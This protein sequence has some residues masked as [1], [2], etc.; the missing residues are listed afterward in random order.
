MHLNGSLSESLVT[1]RID[2]PVALAFDWIHQ[3]LYWADVGLHPSRAKI[4]V[5]TLY[6]RWRHTL[7]DESVVRSPEVVVVD[8]RADQGYCSLLL[9]HVQFTIIWFLCKLSRNKC[10]KFSN[11]TDLMATFQYTCVTQLHGLDR[12]F[13][14]WMLFCHPSK[15]CRCTCR[16]INVKLKK[17]FLLSFM[18]SL[19][20]VCVCGTDWHIP[21]SGR[22]DALDIQE[23]YV[24]GKHLHWN[25]CERI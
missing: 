19:L 11:T 9:V 10:L 3:N 20:F 17:F 7:L 23:M 16:L 12:L 8:P 25:C 1:T 18:L 13:P 4:E 22:S 2:N 15:Q 21:Q 6:N 14:D 24:V 5:L